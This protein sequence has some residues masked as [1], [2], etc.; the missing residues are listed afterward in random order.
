MA[1]KRPA[2][3]DGPRLGLKTGRGNDGYGVRILDHSQAKCKSKKGQI[4]KKDEE[5]AFSR[6]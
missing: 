4:Q 5:M 3:I 6:R 2:K 1:F